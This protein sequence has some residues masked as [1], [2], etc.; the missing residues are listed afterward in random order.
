MVR[1]SNRLVI[2]YLVLTIA[3]CSGHLFQTIYAQVWWLLVPIVGLTILWS[4]QTIK[5][6][7][8]IGRVQMVVILFLIMIVLTWVQS[9]G[10]GTS[11]YI[12]MMLYILAGY[13]VSRMYS[14][15]KIANCYV[16]CMTVVTVIAILGYFLVQNTSVFNYFPSM[17]NVNGIE[18]CVAGVFNYVPEDSVRNCGMF[19]EPGLFATHLVLAMIFEI[20]LSRK[21]NIIRL[22]IFSIGIFT[23]NSSAGF[24]LWFLCIMLIF[25]KNIKNRNS[26]LSA[27]S[28]ILLCFG[29]I[30]IVHYEQILLQ[31]GLVENEFI[32]KLLIQNIEDS[33]RIK[34]VGHNLNSF[35]SAPIFGVGF[36]EAS[37]NMLYV[38]DTSTSTYMMSVFGI[39]GVL[40]TICWIIGVVKLPRINVLEKILLILIL[41]IIINKEP[42]IKLLFSWCLLFLLIR[43][44][45]PLSNNE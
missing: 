23:A 41:L 30:I 13:G 5:E 29:I 24:L 31:T 28:F 45:S 9:L 4:L 21:V 32:Y 22:I 36:S 3:L 43:G 27:L 39:S 40:Y 17:I 7:R 8:K 15:M 19:W 14:F 12:S 16:R 35:L 38:A 6:K 11:S 33:S 26:V 18:Y 25:C 1:S 42:H 44:I 34:A 2:A 37:K 10:R 20:M